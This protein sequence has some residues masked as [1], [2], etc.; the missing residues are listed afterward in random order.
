MIL[1]TVGAQLPFDRLVRAVDAWAARSGRR[2]V[3]AQI[4]PGGWRPA[5]VEWAEFIEP[6]EF[7]ERALAA[8]ALVGHAG[9]GTI[10]TALQFG[11]PVLV[12]PRRGDLGETRNDHQVATAERFAAQRR[13]R[14]AMDVE[15]LGPRLDELGGQSASERIGPFAE[16]SL[17]HAL[18]EF[19]AGAEAEMTHA[20]R[21]RSRPN[22]R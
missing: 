9:M 16:E 20:T 17:L 8:D 2:D 5:H 18:R 4:G 21:G 22:G 10:L 11:K 3:F 15:E 6:A 13:I 7:R 12:M 1:V 19:I 14:V